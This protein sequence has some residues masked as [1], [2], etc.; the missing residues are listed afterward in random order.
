M[1]TFIDNLLEFSKM[2]AKN[3][4]LN[5]T[6]FDIKENVT[7]ILKMNYFKSK[8][9]QNKLKLFVSDNFPKKI[10]ADE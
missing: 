2:K 5:K 4:E 10:L 7:N 6:S 1:H 3:I 9:K 8:E